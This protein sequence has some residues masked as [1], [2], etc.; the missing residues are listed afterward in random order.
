MIEKFALRFELERVL[1]HDGVGLVEWQARGTYRANNVPV[2]LRGGQVL[3]FS[4]DG[5]IATEHSYSDTA[6]VAV[7]VGLLSGRV[8]EATPLRG[9]TTW[10][11]PPPSPHDAELVQRVRSVWTDPAA[12]AS[13][14]ADDVVLDEVALPFEAKGK[15]DALEVMGS[16]RTAMPDLAIRVEDAW[17]FGDVV[18]M[19]TVLAGTQTAPLHGLDATGKRLAL[20]FLEV[21]ETRGDR[22]VRIRRYA[23]R[24][25]WLTEMG[26]VK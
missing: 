24:L 16:Y 19:T 12:L 7:Q 21:V 2:H 10:V 11:V 6:S 25:E 23:N 5:H 18:V 4:D 15:H 8:R 17:A 13:A 3:R 20:H 26:I 9:S 14:L 1:L 22:I